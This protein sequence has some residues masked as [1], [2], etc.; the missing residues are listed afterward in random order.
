MTLLLLFPQA[1]G[2]VIYD[3]SIR[4]VF[5]GLPNDTNFLSFD[6]NNDDTVDITFK[7]SLSTF[8]FTVDGPD[9]TNVL[10]LTNSNTG[11]PIPLSPGSL[12]GRSGL[13]EIYTFSSLRD[14]GGLLSFAFEDEDLVTGGPF[15]NQEAYLGFE[16]EADI[17]SHFGY[18]LIREAGGFGGF[19]LETGYETNPDTSIIAGAIPEPSTIILTGFGLS[20]IMRRKR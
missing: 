17:G 15:L 9:T 20:L 1:R 16:F 12:I 2:A 5:A 4:S 11:G 14:G 8:Q 3:N 13:D 6:L 10:T 19:F 7:A 18:I